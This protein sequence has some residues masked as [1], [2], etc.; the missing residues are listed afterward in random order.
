MANY[1]LNGAERALAAAMAEGEVCDLSGKTSKASR[2]VRP[3]ALR[4]L[5]FGLPVVTTEGAAPRRIEITPGG[6]RLVGA[7]VEQGD[8]DLDLRDAATWDG[9]PLPP[10]A[11]ENC[12]I[13]RPIRLTGGKLRRLSLKGSAIVHLE[14]PGLCLDGD[15]DLSDVF[16]AETATARTGCEGAACCWVELQGSRIDGSIVAA[17]AR[18]AAGGRTPA[19]RG[20][21][22]AR[23]ALN[24]RDAHVRDCLELRPGFVAVGGVKINQVGGDVR[25]DGGTITASEGTALEGQGGDIGGILALRPFNAQ[26]QDAQPFTANGNI[27]L[28]GAR[29]R[30]TFD[31]S[32]ADVRGEVIVSNCDIGGDAFLRCW[33]GRINGK[34]E[35]L[36]FRAKGDIYLHTTKVGRN[37]EADG[38][39]LESGIVAPNLVTGGEFRLGIWRD[40][41]ALWKRPLRPRADGL[42]NLAGAQITG[43][44][45][46]VGAQMKGDFNIQGAEIAGS[47]FLSQHDPTMPF[48]VLGRANL[49]GAEIECDLQ[50]QG[51]HIHFLRAAQLEVGGHVDI[52][53]P[54]QVKVEQLNFGHAKV[55]GNLEI[56]ASLTDGAIS[57]EQAEIE[58]RL[59]L[60]LASPVES[61]KKLSFLQGLRDGVQK[62]REQDWRALFAPRPV[63]PAKLDLSFARVG[64]LDDSGGS[65]VACCKI[66]MEG[67]AYGRLADAE[68]LPSPS[69]PDDRKLPIFELQEVLQ[70]WLPQS[71]ATFA[72]LVLILGEIALLAF[73]TKRTALPLYGLAALALTIAIVCFREWR[74]APTLAEGRIQWLGRQYKDRKPRPE[75]YRP[76]PYERLARYF[77]GEG[78]YAEARR[79]AR[80][81]LDL[82]RKLK[83]FVLLRPALWCYG[84]LFDYGMSPVRAINV[85]LAFILVGSIG[86]YVADNGLD[87]HKPPPVAPFVSRLP[88]AI[89]SVLVVDAMPV[90]PV[91]VDKEA[92]FDAPGG[93]GATTS[94]LD[95]GAQIEPIVYALDVF[96]PALD[97]RQESKCAVTT[98]ADAWPWRAA[99]ASYSM[100]GW[101]VSSLTIL[102]IS[103]ILRRQA[104]G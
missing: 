58:D 26:G 30:G 49:V 46:M 78:L 3:A 73:D 20:G 76:E 69:P 74:I 33:K 54:P 42:I 6:L 91:A 55:R 98:R 56:R 7:I 22:L 53:L 102:T 89:P 100:L 5:L 29:I 52:M 13:P 50:M 12:H 2:T 8:E 67:F 9:A 96:V 4:R 23:F 60:A 62:L 97:L 21:Q 72:P 1:R 57:L 10:L 70:R 44:L 35:G 27:W 15:L 68:R 82:E 37:F 18:L 25:I 28:L 38:A 64:T 63:S 103:G 61:K 95:C 93:S 104:E 92:R 81:R 34:E 90:N 86:V 17:S 31:M 77:R 48:E 101:I 47:A 43:N 88:T 87:P 75:E 79:I 16:S 84:L 32:G 83:T 19:E 24:L 41:A 14:A 51:A 40:K 11:L 39:L 45:Y 85:F 71:V 99:L 94:E 65:G 66:D 80:A 36:P 59:L